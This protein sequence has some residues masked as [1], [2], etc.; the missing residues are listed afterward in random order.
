MKVKFLDQLIK[1]L[2]S[3][4]ASRSVTSMGNMTKT[5]TDAEK[6]YRAAVARLLMWHH[7]ECDEKLLEDTLKADL[8]SGLDW[9]PYMK[10]QASNFRNDILSY[11][12]R[13]IVM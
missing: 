4:V 8:I 12:M 2:N 11:R 7:H 5:G 1:E 13:A 9:I 6:N 10:A 3:E